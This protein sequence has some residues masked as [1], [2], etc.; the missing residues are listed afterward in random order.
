M[1]EAETVR[2]A[3]MKVRP[4]SEETNERRWVR[5]RTLYMDILCLEIDED[6]KETNSQED[7]IPSIY[8]Y[9][10]NFMTPGAVALEALVC[11]WRLK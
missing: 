11:L 1:F 7:I 4:K 6:R 2:Q 10:G 5:R 8:P 3:A 9:L